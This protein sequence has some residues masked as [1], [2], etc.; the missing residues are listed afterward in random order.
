MGQFVML[1]GHS[2]MFYFKGLQSTI[3]LCSLYC[4]AYG[5]EV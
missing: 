3:P 2:L 4:L 5:M 1:E